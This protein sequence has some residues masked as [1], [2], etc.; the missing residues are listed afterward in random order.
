MGFFSDIGDFLGD[1]V[2]GAADVL[3]GLFGGGGG[4]G[5][6]SG[7]DASA[8]Q[9]LGQIMTQT[10]QLLKPQTPPL[11]P[12]VRESDRGSLRMGMPT[13]S[14]PI[15]TSDPAKSLYLALYILSQ[16]MNRPQE[17]LPGPP[18]GISPDYGY[19]PGFYT[20]MLRPPY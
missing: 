20:P 10:G 18:V 17:P 8:L 16:M 14:Q 2:G 19:G 12:S 6:G 9:Q 3:G 11:F 13:S 5:K 15:A 7:G 1:V 4:G